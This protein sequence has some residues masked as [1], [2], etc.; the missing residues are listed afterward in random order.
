M[1]DDLNLELEQSKF[2]KYE[3]TTYMAK[4]TWLKKL[5]KYSRETKAKVHAYCYR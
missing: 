5:Y 1:I 4:S 2:D 3:Y